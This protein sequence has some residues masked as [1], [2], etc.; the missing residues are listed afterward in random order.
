MPNGRLQSALCIA[1]TGLVLGLGISGV[2]SMP[3]GAAIGLVGGVAA[4]LVG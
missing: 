1:V 4:G 2:I 3:V